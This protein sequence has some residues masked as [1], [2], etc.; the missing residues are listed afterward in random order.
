VSSARKISNAEV[1]PF[2]RILQSFGLEVV[3]GKTIGTATEYQLAATDAER[4]ADLQAMLD[5]EDVKA[6]FFARGGY[7]SVRVVDLIDRT[8]FLKR[9][10]WLVGYSDVTVFLADSFFR[11]DVA[12]IHATMAINVLETTA[13]NAPSV[14]TLRQCL[15]GDFQPI[16]WGTHP[17]N[18]LGEADAEVVGGNLSVLY[19]LLSSCSFGETDGKIL[20]IEDVDE[21]LYHADR[22]MMALKRAGKLSNLS[23]LVVGA[24][25]DMRDNEIGWGKGINEIIYEAVNEYSYPV[26]F[27]FP[28]GHIGEM[29]HAFVHGAR[30]KLAVGATGCRFD[31][32]K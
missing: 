26:C 25:S 9:P 20:V 28:F 24:F 4:A 16:A 15:F 2:K 18:R 29:N 17:Y 5:A 32:M 30:T 31:Q 22:M 19:S 3:T 7:G 27:G 23:A 12:A 6:V 13:L 8:A 11:C 14:E 10:K 1:E 21:Y